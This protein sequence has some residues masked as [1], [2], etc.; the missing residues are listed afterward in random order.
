[1][2]YPGRAWDGFPAPEMAEYVDAACKRLDP[3][4]KWDSRH[5][6]TKINSKAERRMRAIGAVGHESRCTNRQTQYMIELAPEV[7]I[8]RGPSKYCT[9]YDRNV[10]T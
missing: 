3:D 6:K 7:A 5:E 4:H 9:K 2:G 10:R 1:M 8:S